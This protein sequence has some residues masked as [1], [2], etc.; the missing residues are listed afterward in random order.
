MA[1]V[2]SRAVEPHDP[3]LPGQEWGSHIARGECRG[4]GEREGG[5]VW[6]Q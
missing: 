4:T 1:K 6:L 3:H 5:S 2:S